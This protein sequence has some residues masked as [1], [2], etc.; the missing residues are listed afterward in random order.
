MT[1]NRHIARESLVEADG[2]VAEKTAPVVDG[3]TLTG[4]ATPL[5]ARCDGDHLAA[6]CPTLHADGGPATFAADAEGTR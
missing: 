1:D 2:D 5:C 4:A 6:D 3:D